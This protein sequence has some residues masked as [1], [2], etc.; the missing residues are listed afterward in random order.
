M[1]KYLVTG[2][3]GFIGSRLL[4]LLKTIKCDVR[5][6]ARSK[7]NN[8][9]TVVCNLNQERIP[10]HALESIDTV[11]H[12][13]GLAHDVKNPLTSSNLYYDVNVTATI[14]LAKAAADCGV[15]SFIFVSSTKS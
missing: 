3:T 2:S 6:L 15:K 13:A 8:Y 7:V 10:N 4:G 11:F 1:T 14:D 9:E 5:L 12:L